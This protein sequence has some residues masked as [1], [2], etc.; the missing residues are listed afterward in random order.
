MCAFRTMTL[1]TFFSYLIKVAHLHLLH[2]MRYLIVQICGGNFSSG[3]SH[4]SLICLFLEVG[5]TCRFP[6]NQ[7]VW[8]DLNISLGWVFE[9]TVPTLV[10]SERHSNLDIYTANMFLRITSFKY[11]WSPYKS[12]ILCFRVWINLTSWKADCRWSFYLFE[13]VASMFLCERGRFLKL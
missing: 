9:W 1:W 5:L 4:V 12:S 2:R 7:Q 6:R 13:S 8:W 3:S 11:C 10:E